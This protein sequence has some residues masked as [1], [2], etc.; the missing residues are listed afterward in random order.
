MVQYQD[1]LLA[2]EEERLQEAPPGIR[3]QAE[4]EADLLV[5]ANLSREA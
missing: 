3:V 4:G 2:I 5:G 1:P